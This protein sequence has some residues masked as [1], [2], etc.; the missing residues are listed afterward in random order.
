[1]NMLD[2]FSNAFFPIQLVVLEELPCGCALYCPDEHAEIHDFIDCVARIGLDIT[3]NYAW[4]MFGA[5]DPAEELVI[6]ERLQELLCDNLNRL[7]CH[8]VFRLGHDTVSPWF[9]LRGQC[10]GR[11]LPTS[12]KRAAGIRRCPDTRA[13]NP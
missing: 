2:G 6:D 5:I 12:L 10:S 7:R 9:L 8:S 11:E 4:E 1:M 3:L 13:A